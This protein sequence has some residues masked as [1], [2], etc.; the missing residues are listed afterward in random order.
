MSRL[1]H[2]FFLH[3]IKEKECRNYDFYRNINMKRHM[4]IRDKINIAKGK[5]N[6]CVCKFY[7]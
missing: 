1:L 7:V 2:N 6:Y 5:V 4:L 3:F